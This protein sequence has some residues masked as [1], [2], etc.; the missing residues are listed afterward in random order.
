MTLLD[1][2]RR[3]LVAMVRTLVRDGVPDADLRKRVTEWLRIHPM[4]AALSDAVVAQ[5]ME[6]AT[7]VRERTLSPGEQQAVASVL[8]VGSER[9]ATIG[10]RVNTRILDELTRGITEGVGPR[11]IEQRIGR[12]VERSAAH[13]ATVV[14]TGQ[15]A[16]DRLHAFQQAREAG[17]DRFRFTGPS[18]DRP[19]CR[20]HYGKIYALEEIDRM[21][22]GQGLS[23][24]T[25]GGGWNCRHT[26]EPAVG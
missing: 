26:W 14:N 22:N 21:D 11:E 12:V 24:R 13:V 17:I 23:V 16:F 15:A 18:P 10:G 20:E 7:W 4:P 8:A 3:E 5:T 9:L 2:Y 6:E 25:H 19:F 1:R